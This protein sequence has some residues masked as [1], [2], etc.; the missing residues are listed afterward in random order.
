MP[1]S[2]RPVSDEPAHSDRFVGGLAEAIGGPLGDHAVRNP[3]RPL[4]A[5]RFWTPVRIVLALVCLTLALHWVQKSPCRDGAWVDLKQYKYFCYTDVLALY[6][7]EHLNEGAIPY[8]GYPV[9]YPV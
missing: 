9:E 5:T 2:V 1:S 7:A 4:G 6:Y 3:A 8:A